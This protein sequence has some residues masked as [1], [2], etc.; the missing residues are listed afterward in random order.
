MTARLVE[1]VAELQRRLYA[2]RRHAILI[3]LQ[4][5][6]TSGKD[7]TIRHVFGGL[8]PQ[9]ITVTSFGVPT[10]EERSHD[11][12][13]RVHRAAPG[14]GSIGIFN[15]SHYEDVLVVRAR[16][17]APRREWEPRFDQINAFEQL[18]S[19]SGTTVLK[20]Y[21]H[22]SKNEQQKR[23]IARLDDPTKN[24]KFRIGD[25]EDRER[26]N[27][28]T[29]AYRD[30][31]SRCSTRWAPWYVVPGDRKPARDYLVAQLLLERLR[32][33]R[34]K[35]PPADPKVLKYRKEIR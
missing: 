2:E 7:G 26:W 10:E 3:V 14:R 18:L 16:A 31:L 6:D 11:F 13:W 21:L 5:R 19:Q 1:Q 4:G 15:R 17:L 30:A 29:T 28:Y 23:L 9:G 20:F 8:N 33:L 34:P 25:L 35:F 27:A 32:A 12:L 24:W 22:I